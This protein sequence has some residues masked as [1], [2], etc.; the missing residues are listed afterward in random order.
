M[1]RRRVIPPYRGVSNNTTYIGTPN[2]YCPPES[3]R[4]VRCYTPAKDRPTIGQR[5]GLAPLFPDLTDGAAVQGLGVVSRASVIT[6]YTLGTCDPVGADWSTSTA[7]TL[8]GHL[9]MLDGRRGMYATSYYDATTDGAPSPVSAFA[10][11]VNP[12]GTLAAYAMIYDDGSPSN[13]VRVRVVSTVDG[14]TVWTVKIAET[15]VNRFV[16]TMT[17][18]EN[19]LFVC[20]NNQLRVYRA[21]TGTAV[22]TST[23]N[24]WAFE[25]I[26]CCV[27][28]DGAFLYVGFNG[29]ETGATLPSGVTV[30]AG[31]YARMWRAGV[32]KFQIN[33]TTSLAAIE[34]VSF[35]TQLLPANTYY[36]TGH[37]YWRFSEQT[38][39]APWGVEIRGIAAHPDGGVVL[40][41]TNQGRGPNA[42]FP[43]DPSIRQ[44]FTLTKLNSN[45][46]TLWRHDTDSAIEPEIGDLGYQNDIPTTGT[47]FPSVMCLT[48]TASGTV[49]AAGRINTVAAYGVN[50]FAIRGTDG[51]R[52]WEQDLGGLINEGCIALD[53]TD[54]NPILVG[55]RNAAWPGAGGNNA[56]LWRLSSVTGEVLQDNDLNVAATGLGVGVTTSGDIVYATTKV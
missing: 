6:G 34:Q 3:M 24:G 32:M 22:Q 48:V 39:W 12:A 54:D 8:D 31:R 53:P 17:F 25:V 26:Q 49:I 55:V 29:L 19:Y 56:H 15:G 21:T 52:L 28:A 23:M 43:P 9:W 2:G 46:V 16:N 4:N 40:A 38:P 42:S 47:D 18:S 35:G 11:A 37:G 20:T 1:A 27:S 14:S 5:P 44:F 41:H 51:V 30:T 7:G 50:V 45:G 36:E 10:V 33:P 13:V